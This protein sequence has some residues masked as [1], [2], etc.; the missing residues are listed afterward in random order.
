MRGGVEEAVSHAEAWRR[1]PPLLD[2]SRW[3]QVPG[4]PALGRWLPIEAWHAARSEGGG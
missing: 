1:Q 4:P 2:A 3:R